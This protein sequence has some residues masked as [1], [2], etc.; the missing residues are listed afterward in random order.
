[1][2]SSS[3]QQG[4]LRAALL[5]CARLVRSQ[6]P[7]PS[8]CYLHPTRQQSPQPPAP[9]RRSLGWWTSPSAWAPCARPRRAST[10]AP[11]TEACGGCVRAH[12][13]ACCG[14]A[15]VQNERPRSCHNSTAPQL[16]CASGCAQPLPRTSPR[17]VLETKP[18]VLLAAA[19]RPWGKW[20]AEIR[21]PQRSTRR[22]LGTYDSAAEVSRG[23]NCPHWHK[24]RNRAGSL[25]AL[26]E[27][28]PSS[29]S[30]SS[31]QLRAPSHPARQWPPL[32]AASASLT[33]P[34]A[35]TPS[36]QAARAYDAAA[37]AIRGLTAKTNFSYPFQLGTAVQPRSGRVS[38]PAPG[39]C[40]ARW[41]HKS[42]AAGGCCRARRGC[43][44][45][46]ALQA[47]KE[48]GRAWL[49]LPLPAPPHKPTCLLLRL[50]GPLT[51]G[52]TQARAERQRVPEG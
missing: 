48:A 27:A 46:V 30:C 5:P 1:M 9:L 50:P 35:G 23:P 29:T 39:C 11:A 18:P 47:S 14:R 10:T 36:P 20:A 25:R 31:H 24:L 16:V 17:P 52:S 38:R 45:H 26:G 22:W 15:H 37:A 12:L 21:D 43:Q 2:R 42:S 6:R 7:T 34:A 13:H 8:P 19:Q 49:A 40:C 51:A 44:L 41:G 4:G 32:A 3:R 33:P 28:T